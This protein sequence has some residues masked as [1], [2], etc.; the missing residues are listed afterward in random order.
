MFVNEIYCALIYVSYPRARSRLPLLKARKTRRV[1]CPGNAVT[2]DRD[3]C[4]K[5]DDHHQRIVDEPQIEY[6]VGRDLADAG[7]RRERDE[8]Q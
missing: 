3:A 1:V 4:A 8:G 5:E 2:I 7:F 6:R